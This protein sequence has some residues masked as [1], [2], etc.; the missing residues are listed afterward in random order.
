MVSAMTE[1]SQLVK[2]VQLEDTEEYPVD[3]KSDPLYHPDDDELDEIVAE[4][5]DD[6]NLR[7]SRYGKE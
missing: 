4:T 3:D 7:S 5:V 6:R 2:T 1:D